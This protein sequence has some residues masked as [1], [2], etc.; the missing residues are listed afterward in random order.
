M[1]IFERPKA[2]HIVLVAGELCPARFHR[3]FDITSCEARNSNRQNSCETGRALALVIG[4]NGHLQFA[5][6]D[7]VFTSIHATRPFSI[8]GRCCRSKAFNLQP[9]PTLHN[10]M[11]RRGGLLCSVMCKSPPGAFYL[12]YYLS[13]SSPTRVLDI[14]TSYPE[15]SF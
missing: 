14:H 4:K 15:V 1:T 2:G 8:F 9:P 10:E 3:L 12:P 6:A 7:R 5:H 11:Q 13:S